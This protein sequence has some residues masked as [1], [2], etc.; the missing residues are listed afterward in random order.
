MVKNLPAADGE[1]RTCGAWYG[2]PTNSHLSTVNYNSANQKSNT[3]TSKIPRL[4]F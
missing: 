1:E 3:P 2:G 4:H